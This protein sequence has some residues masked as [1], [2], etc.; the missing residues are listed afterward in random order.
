MP[1]FN[2]IVFS[3]E[4]EELHLSPAEVRFFKQFS[5]KHCKSAKL[6]WHHNMI[7]LSQIKF[8]GGLITPLKKFKKCQKIIKKSGGKMKTIFEK[9]LGKD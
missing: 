9:K 6:P 2:D 5:K 4:E 1:D 8:F 3:E 7:D